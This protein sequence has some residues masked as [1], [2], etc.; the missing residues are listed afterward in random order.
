[1][2]DGR[3]GGDPYWYT[4]LSGNSKTFTGVYTSALGRMSLSSASTAVD[5]HRGGTPGRRAVT[6]TPSD[7]G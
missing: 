1:M 2:N 3:P 5:R 4:Y 6:I 7:A